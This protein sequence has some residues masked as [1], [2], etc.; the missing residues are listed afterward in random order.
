MPCHNISPPHL[1]TNLHFDRPRLGL[2]RRRELLNHHSQ[3]TALALGRNS[4]RVRVLRQSEP[5][6]ELGRS[7]PLQ[8]DVLAAFLFALVSL[9]L[10][11]VVALHYQHILIL[12]RHLHPTVSKNHQ[13]LVQQC[14]Y[15]I[16]VEN[17]GAK[18]VKIRIFKN[19]IFFELKVAKFIFLYF[20]FFS[21]LKMKLDFT[22]TQRV[23]NHQQLVEQFTRS[24]NVSNFNPVRYDAV[25]FS[26]FW[27]ILPFLSDD[28]AKFCKESQQITSN[29]YKF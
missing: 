25:E 27:R 28:A 21:H 11:V 9:P 13:K 7:L 20:F 16:N 22:R 10:P 3:H 23:L 19:Y 17:F 14:T 18:G 8:P 24:K 6:L 4:G 26:L 1:S 5:P 2:G 29:T 15:Y 12:Q